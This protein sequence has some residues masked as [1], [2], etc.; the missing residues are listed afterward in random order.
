MSNLLQKHL[1]EACKQ[2]NL[3]LLKSQWDFDSKLIP[4]ALQ[5]IGQLFPHYSRHDQSHSDQI[6]I[7]IERILGDRVS[8]L[9]ATDTW[10]L[11]EAAYWHDLGMVVPNRALQEAL[12]DT[13]FHSYLLQIA[14]D[15]GNE[16]QK[17]A[18]FFLKTSDLTQCFTG[19]DYPLDAV[20][21]FRLLMAEWFRRKHPTRSEKAMN[22]PWNELGLSSPRSELIPTRL[23]RLLGRICSLH[24]ASFSEILS[25]LPHKEVGMANDDCHP[26][27]VACLLRLGDLLDMDD[28]RFCPVMQRIAGDNRP[29]LSKAHE[30]KHSSIRHFRLDNQRI[31]IYAVCKSIDG[32]VEQWRWLD[33]LRDEMQ[34]QM[35]R[36]QDI[37]PSVELGLLPMLGDIKVDIADRALIAESGKRP[38]FT[39]NANRVMDLLKGDNLYDRFDAFRELLQNAVDATLLRIWECDNSAIEQMISQGRSGNFSQEIFNKYPVIARLERISDNENKI[40]WCLTISD[41]GV[42]I[43][44]SD[45]V[46][47]TKVA[48]SSNN[49]RRLSLINSMPEWLQPSGTFGIGLQSAFMW[50]E[51][52]IIKTK[53]LYSQE[54]LDIILHSPTGTKKGLVEVERV[55]DY[56][57]PIGT[58]LSIEIETERKSNSFSISNENKQTLYYLA[59]ANCDWLLDQELPLDAYRLIDEVALFSNN[60]PISVEC[61]FES[62]AVGLSSSIDTTSKLN[63]FKETNSRFDIIFFDQANANNNSLYYR[64]QKVKDDKGLWCY[65]F[66]NYKI[67][68]YSGKASEWLTF[69][70]NSLSFKGKKAVPNVVEE[71]IR[72]WFA[73]NLEYVMREN[74]P[75]QQAGQ[76]HP[77]V[78]LSA[79][80][81]I[82]S[83]DKRQEQSILDFWESISNKTAELWKDFPCTVVETDDNFDKN[84]DAKYAA[85][86]LLNPGTLISNS[87][88]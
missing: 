64:G 11:L 65:P 55:D 63:F 8:L 62:E 36:W 51:K 81:K 43:N 18:T 22:D 70:R 32:Y 31:E 72:L 68:L 76:C 6:L 79:F 23:F 44:Q 16:L 1:E 13:D 30:D 73:K 39:L 21:K 59:I 42:G 47:M 25:D 3:N 54:A 12:D 9:S 40:C 19:A 84:K 17:F 53:G 20:I 41:Q 50:S 85:I 77:K 58:S 35:A 83:F 57:R 49:I 29:A 60:S 88:S 38:E 87:S 14:N 15:A 28:N 71:N 34:N 86:Q 78:I 69:N 75:F 33:M 48:G 74:S 7:N 24:G 2:E 26:R 46:Y 37:A 45:M 4:K 66:F 27:F 67:D 61:F 56:L 5:T 10:M 52:I 82:E 80:A